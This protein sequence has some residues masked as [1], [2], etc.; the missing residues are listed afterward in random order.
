MR[1]LSLADELRSSGCD[2]LFVCR[3]LPGGMEGY[4]AK[5]GYCSHVFVP[6][7]D[8]IY[9]DAGSTIKAIQSVRRPQ[10]LIIDHYGIDLQWELLVKPYA[11]KLLV[12][13]DLANRPHMADVL[14]DQNLSSLNERRYD[15][16]VPI[17][18]RR[19]VGPSYLLLRPSFYTARASLDRRGGSV[20]R[21]LVFFGGSDPTNETSK[22]LQALRSLKLSHI[23]IDV[24]IGSSNPH[25]DRVQEL[26]AQ[27]ANAELHIQAENMA[28]LIAKADFALGAGGTAMWE[29]CFLGLPSSV[30]AVSDN[31][32]E[33]AQLAGQLGAVWYLGWHEQINEG[34][35]VD[36]VTR[37][38]SSRSELQELGRR[39]TL[40]VSP[41]ETIDE[42]HGSRVL[43]VLMEDIQAM[44]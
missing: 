41:N 18:C 44:K 36:I 24:V 5:R 2:I 8:D 6:E 4:L 21:L 11:D 40:A 20:Q 25:Q 14:L 38:M 10:W 12:I 27:L 22:A 28:E 7:H 33:A 37:A 9:S 43:T 19:L 30:T 31:Q 29:R 17:E 39:A 1:C 15:G 16:L 3:E 32:V 34:H 13:D 42:E 23:A 26:F 35:Y